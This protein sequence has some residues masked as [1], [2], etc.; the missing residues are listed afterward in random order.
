MKTKTFD[1]VEMM[2]KGAAEVRRR[3]KGMSEKERIEY[4]RKR[5][6]QL[7]ARQLELRSSRDSKAKQ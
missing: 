4:W 3:L 7:R 1:C 5:T 6:E 2:H